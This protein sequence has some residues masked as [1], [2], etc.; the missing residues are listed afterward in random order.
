M[1]VKAYNSYFC[2][3]KFRYVVRFLLQVK[4]L[5]LR[6]FSFCYPTQKTPIL[7]PFSGVY[8]FLFDPPPPRGGKQKKGQKTGFARKK[9]L[10]GDKKRGK[11]HIFS[12]TG[13]K[14]SYF[15]PDWLKIYKIAKKGYKFFT[16]GAHPLIESL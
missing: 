5:D 16:C 3:S 9:L 12:A 15:F 7:N 14:Y 13:K 4:Y 11:M 10:K 1:W 2:V 6:E 8:I